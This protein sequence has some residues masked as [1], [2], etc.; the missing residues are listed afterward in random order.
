MEG[1]R[2]ITAVRV[3]AKVEGEPPGEPQD[4]GSAGASPSIR[5]VAT[6]GMWHR[7]NVWTKLAARRIRQ[8]AMV[9]E[10]EQIPGK[11]SLPEIA[12][13]NTTSRD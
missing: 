6:R 1:R 4:L 9:H 11:A 2:K 3:L 5:S 8:K 12:K 10:K 7:I 13:T